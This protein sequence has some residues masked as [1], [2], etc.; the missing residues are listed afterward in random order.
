MADIHRCY[1][2][3]GLPKEATVEDIKRQHRDLVNVWHPDRFE[4]NPRLQKKAEEN[5]AEINAAYDTLNIFLESGQPFPEFHDQA[6]KPQDSRQNSNSGCSP[7]GAYDKEDKPNQSNREWV[8][9][10]PKRSWLWRLVFLFSIALV[11]A[12]L[13][14][15]PKVRKWY[16]ILDNPAEYLK[17]TV[18]SAAYE[19]LGEVTQANNPQNEPPKVNNPTKVQEQPLIKELVEIRLVDGSVIA[20][21]SCKIKDDM[22]VYELNHGSMGIERSRVKS[23][24]V[25]K[26]A[27]K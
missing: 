26:I 9:R 21:K 20:A 17:H 27:S 25:I 19:I 10:K 24:R 1:K 2:V 6:A 23:I 8:E 18:K 12:S 3:L 5:M 13:F 22:L 15:I 7:E 14:I 16:P 4:G 11:V